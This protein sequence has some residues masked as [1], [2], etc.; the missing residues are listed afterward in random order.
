VF[1]GFRQDGLLYTSIPHAG[2][3]KAYVDG[4]EVEIISIGVMVSIGA[5]LVFLALVGY[6]RIKGSRLAGKG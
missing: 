4:A 6:G 1:S 5:V 2:L 3:W